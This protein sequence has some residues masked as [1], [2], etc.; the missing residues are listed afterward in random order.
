MSSGGGE[1]GKKNN[2]LDPAGILS[3]PGGFL[4]DPFRQPRELAQANFGTSFDVTR[5]GQPAEQT[6][7]G[8]FTTE[9]Q[10]ARREQRNVDELAQ[11]LGFE[12]EA[13]RQK[14]IA[15]II[16]SFARRSGR[17]R[18]GPAALFNQ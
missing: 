17:R 5:I 13:D 14:K 8:E 9:R 11:R 6:V 15:N 4:E 2:P 18:A 12:N 10:Q 1:S 7:T 3:D 16:S